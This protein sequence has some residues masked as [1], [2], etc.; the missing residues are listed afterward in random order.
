MQTAAAAGPPAGPAVELGALGTAHLGVIGALLELEDDHVLDG[1]HGEGLRGLRRRPRLVCC[2]SLDSWTSRDVGV[3]MRAGRIRRQ[4]ADM[5]W[6]TNAGS[7][8]SCVAVAGD[9]RLGSRSLHT[10]TP[11]CCDRGDCSVP[12]L[13]NDIKHTSTHHSCSNEHRMRYQVAPAG[14]RSQREGCCMQIQLERTVCVG[15]K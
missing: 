6:F 1:R 9:A 11:C 4:R 10:C 13:R 5:Q 8:S 7:A 14:S 3:Q 15:F 12:R 2:P